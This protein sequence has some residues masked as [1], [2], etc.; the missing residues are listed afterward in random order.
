MTDGRQKMHTDG[1]LRR[2]LASVPRIGAPIGFEGRVRRKI[3]SGTAA[4]TGGRRRFT[5]VA[6]PALSLAAAAGVAVIIYLAPFGGDDGGSGAPGSPPQQSTPATVPGKPALQDGNTGNT[7]QETRG[8]RDD[9]G[10]SKGTAPEKRG[11]AQ[12]KELLSAPRQTSPRLMKT[13]PEPAAVAKPSEAR[14]AAAPSAVPAEVSVADSLAPKDSAGT[15][16]TEMKP[17][18]TSVLRDTAA[19]LPDP[20]GARSDRPR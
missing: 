8:R 12:T 5:T 1:K 17:D 9:L 7:P 11:E 4:E 14:P 3:A 19:S 15:D 20:G 18:S 6:I 16:S 10:K 2:F 13:Q